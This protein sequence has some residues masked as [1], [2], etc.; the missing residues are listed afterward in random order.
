M[1]RCYALANG[2]RKTIAA[3]DTVASDHDWPGQAAVLK[4]IADPL[5]LLILRVLSDDSFSVSELCEVFALRQSA[6]SHHLK[7]LVTADWLVRRREGTAIYY[8]RQL[9]QGH[10]VALRSA[11]IAQIDGMGL[12]DRVL[13]QCARVQ[14]QREQNSI[15][16]FE[17]HSE[18]LR[19]HQ[20]LI[21]NW[22]D[23]SEASLQL[24]D[25]VTLPD[26]ATLLEIGPGDGA[27]LPALRER[28]SHVVALDKSEAM[29]LEARRRNKGASSIDYLHGDTGYAKQTGILV[30]AI[31]MNMVLHHTSHPQQVIRD[32]ALLLGQ[33]GHLVVSELCAHDQGWARDHCGDLWLGFDPDQLAQWASTAGF[34]LRDK[35]HIAQRNGFQIQF[36]FFKCDQARNEE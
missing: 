10:D 18:R 19:E 7:V 33:G 4:A 32:A 15:A 16:F 5:R 36:N 17:H 21:A 8:R 29:L 30:E 14:I 25:T 20:D 35:V 26:D 28:A 1:L 13:A 3:A 24:L 2:I 12:P 11:V 22:A 27:L 6:L 34:D 23:Y 9:A 31:V